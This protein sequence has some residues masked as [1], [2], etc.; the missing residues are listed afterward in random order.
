MSMNYENDCVNN[1]EYS[2][3]GYAFTKQVVD[4]LGYY[5]KYIM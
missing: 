1:K 4:D 2:K 5:M 3:V